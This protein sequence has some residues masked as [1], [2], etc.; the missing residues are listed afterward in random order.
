MLLAET[1]LDRL[2]RQRSSRATTMEAIEI[3]GRG[4]LEIEALVAEPSLDPDATRGDW[5]QQASALRALTEAVKQGVLEKL[6]PALS[7]AQDAETKAAIGYRVAQVLGDAAAAMCAAGQGARAEGWVKRAAEVCPSEAVAEALMAARNEP[8]VWAAIGRGRFLA[9]AGQVAGAKKC[10][11][12]AMKQARSPALQALAH[13]ALDAPTP[14]TSAPPLFTMNGCGVSL[15]GSRD[16]GP[17]GSYVA[18]YCLCLVFIPVLPL[19]AYRVKRLEDNRYLFGTRVRLGPLARAWQAV[20]GAAAIAAVG[21]GAVT[22]YLESP[23]RNLG[24]AVR[25]AAVVE[26]SGDR[27]A[28]L[29]R[30]RGAVERF[31]ELTNVSDAAEGVVRL[32][33]AAVTEP[34]GPASVDAIG[35]VVAGYFEL[36]MPS[37]TGAVEA[38]LVGK[39]LAW[40]EQIGQSS[41][42]A[43]RASLA[44]LDMAGQVGAGKA[45]GDVDARRTPLRMSL[46]RQLEQERPVD[47]LAHYARVLDDA[48]ARSSAE[49]IVDGLGDSPALWAEAEPHV[50]AL[51]AAAERAGKTDL[52]PRLRERL[53]AASAAHARS[54]ALVEAG[55]EA[56]I[57]AALAAAPRDETLAA[58]IA[59][60][61][62]RRG[63]PAACVAAL[64]PFAP[65]GAAGRLTAEGQLLLGACHSDADATARADQILAG[66]VDERLPAL[67]EA[68]RAYAQ[69][70]RSLEERLVNS[71]RQDTLPADVM[72]QLRAAPE[73]ERSGI[74]QAWLSAQLTADPGLTQLRAAALRHEAVVPASLQ[75]GAVRLRRASE[76]QGDERAALLASAE[77][78][79]VSIRNEAEGAP[80]FHLGLG[81][82]Y[83][84]LGKPEQGDAELAKLLERKEPQLSLQVAHTYREL[85]LEGKAKP[86]AISV[87]QSEAPTPVR[88]A[89]ASLVAK[90]ADDIDERSRWLDLASP[91]DDEVKRERLRIEAERHLRDGKRA[92]ADRALAQ[93]AAEYE[94]D[95][96]HSS[97]AANN[98]ALAHARR[99]NASGDP[100]H[101]RKGVARLELAARGA[102]DSALVAGNLG[103]A[104]EHLGL[105][106]VLDRWV[107]IR[108][109]A[110]GTEEAE[111]LVGSMLAGPLRAEVLRALERDPSFRRSLEVHRTEQILAPTKAAAYDASVQW[112]RWSRDARG[113]AAL[114]QRVDALPPVT[115][116][117]DEA[118][119]RSWEAGERDDSIR[120]QL[121]GWLSS[122]QERVARAQQSGHKPSHAAALA[123]HADLLER[124]A[125]IDST[126]PTIDAAIEAYR[127]ATQ[128]WPDGGYSGDLGVALVTAGVLRAAE[129]SP[130]LKAAWLESRRHLRALDI[131]F[132]AATGSSGPE[133]LAA[134]RARPE[135]AEAARLQAASPDPT[136]G[137]WD[138]MLASLVGDKDFQAR[139]APAFARPDLADAVHL[140]HRLYPS[141]KGRAR[142]AELLARGPIFP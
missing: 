120:K 139:S 114:W 57:L 2:H 29:E 34:C 122:S 103:S 43:T 20:A 41:L 125:A 25:E 81:Q 82:V 117:E 1:G 129:A 106:A 94:R 76:A 86:I 110:P 48:A 21:F 92:D 78:A 17:D 84:R 88:F 112:L 83:H 102:P 59:L 99:F 8:L 85:G 136:P 14:V 12:Q 38:L 63:E 71:A 61:A 98:A 141:S 24:V 27:A 33:A 80:S 72:D 9:R 3:L 55:D 66:L 46:A 67:L 22:S 4:V 49:A 79:F 18:T 111:S 127:K 58:S 64:A 75:L 16:H 107:Q 90:M 31:G 45:H 30:Y 47:A 133:V 135:L 10:F 91:D 7:E 19:A 52:P 116:N 108:T 97:T 128:L 109:L 51:A 140:E 126:L 32:S 44:V 73:A 39:L 69:A 121:T 53:A 119:R 134:L 26:A 132:L 93:V 70:A 62:R 104:L 142:A 87:H 56:Q 60:S 131:A 65:Q 28:A 15:Y 96:E 113:L 100:A 77:H 138:W 101:L 89:A 95:A 54:R 118:S 124:Q 13:E 74:F 123:L 68:Q 115:G 105:V 42:P 11:R 130:P 5:E 37:R 36:P 137:V 6:G 35:R 50:L 40:S 23:S